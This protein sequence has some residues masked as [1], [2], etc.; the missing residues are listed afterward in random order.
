MK[1]TAYFP[2]LTGLRAVA[3][4]CVFFFH[5]PPVEGTGALG[6]QVLHALCREGHIGVSLFFTLSGFLLCRRYYAQP[7]ARKQLLD[8][9]F[10]R[11]ARIWP[12]FFLVTT[13]TFIV[14]WEQIGSSWRLYVGNITL[15][16]GLLPDMAFT[17]VT[18]TWSLTVEE[19]FYLLAPLLFWLG[20]RF[21]PFVWAGVAAALLLIGLLLYNGFGPPDFDTAHFMLV[22][23]IFGRSTEFLAGAA[24]ALLPA[25]AQGQR[26]T[27][28]GG[29]LLL[30][31]VGLFTGLQVHTGKASIDTPL[32]LGLNNGLLPVA[33][34]LLLWGLATETTALQRGLGSGPLQALG[35]ASYCFYLLHMGV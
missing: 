14:Y 3:A 8:Y 21:S 35:K 26:A 22:A 34:G 16:K 12:V 28:A 24:F 4:Y 23:T 2:A 10:R 13:A 33:T 6:W 7:L 9:A 19:C 18:Q 31:L 20:R 30:L 29:L 15:L 25:R 17:G 27:W 32:G 1:P 11:W 5:F